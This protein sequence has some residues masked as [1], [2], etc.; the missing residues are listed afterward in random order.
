MERH[1]LRDLARR[2]AKDRAELFRATAQAMRAHEAI[3]E[4][5]FWVCWTLDYLFRES[6]WKDG[7]ALKG[8]TSLSKAYAAIERFSE[9]IDLILEWRLLGYAADEPWQDRSPTKQD[10][11][12][13]DANRRTVE[14]LVRDFAPVLSRDLRDRAGAELEVTTEGQD[15]LIEYP[16]AFSLGAIRPQIRLEIGP[17]GAW[18]PNEGRTIRPYAA[19]QFPA[20]FTQPDTTARTI[21]VARTFWRRQPSCTKRPTGVRRNRCRPITPAIIT[22]SLD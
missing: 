19:E 5:D 6:S 14:F 16:K 1:T 10:A 9:D 4:K 22:T 8:G 15:V 20:A 13:K 12:G 17:L 21:A 11:F 2:P 3:V 7:I 18:V